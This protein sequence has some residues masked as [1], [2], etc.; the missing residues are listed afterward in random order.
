LLNVGGKGFIVPAPVDKIGFFVAKFVSAVKLLLLLTFEVLQQL[1]NDRGNNNF[2]F[3]NKN[4]S[5]FSQQQ[6]EIGAF[7]ASWLRAFTHSQSCI[8]SPAKVTYVV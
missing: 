2:V 4:K 5:K 6:K 8:L 7:Q 3:V 1:T